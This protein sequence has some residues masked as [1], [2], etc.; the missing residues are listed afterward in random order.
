M[1]RV[2]LTAESPGELVKMYVPGLAIKLFQ[3]EFANRSR[4]V[5]EIDYTQGFCGPTEVPLT[6]KRAQRGLLIT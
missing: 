6:F 4:G 3:S 1:V 2:S 5:Q